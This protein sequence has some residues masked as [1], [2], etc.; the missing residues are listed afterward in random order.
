[1][2]PTQE[3]ATS[4]NSPRFIVNKLTNAHGCVLVICGWKMV[5]GQAGEGAGKGGRLAPVPLMEA[6]VRTLARE[7]CGAEAKRVL[8]ST[9]GV[10]EWISRSPLQLQGPISHTIEM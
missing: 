4:V 7:S 2:Q 3:R 10:R 5:T 8:G 1:M 9:L 6:G